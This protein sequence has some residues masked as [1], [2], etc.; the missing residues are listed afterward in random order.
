MVRL[1]RLPLGVLAIMACCL[2]APAQEKVL[3]KKESPYNMVVVVE[4]GQGLRTL[5]FD[6]GRVRQ[7]VVKPGD[8]D[9]LELAYARVMPVGLAFR[10][11]PQRMLIVGLG[12]GTV[13]MFLHKHYPQAK[14]DAVDIDPVVVD[15]ARTFFGFRDDALLQAHV[16]DGR[17][18][19]ETC[20]EPYDIIFLDAFGAENIPYALAT[21]E[22]LEA[23]RRA[24]GPGGIVV[25]DIWGRWSNR[26]YDSMVRTY[27][28]VFEEVVLFD[29]AGAGN[30]IIVALPRKQKI[31][32]DEIAR[33][34]KRISQ[35][36]GFR[37]D[38]GELVLRGFR[39]PD[40][41]LT[42]GRVLTD[43]DKPQ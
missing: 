32:R 8:P 41:E 4:D 12:G 17:R 26:L 24:L 36:K 18:F 10:E 33:R 31:D 43:K 42:R 35:A 30:K 25:G 3:F 27:H 22:F 28:D 5:S 38:L 16:A 2:A 14:I 6:D 29:V 9:H 20:Q 11:D 21:R 39:R 37:Y 15:V 7:S 40:E 19:I 23:V 34:A 13:P 1:R